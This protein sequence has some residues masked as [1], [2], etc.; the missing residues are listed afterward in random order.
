MRLFNVDDSAHRETVALLPWYVNGTLQHVERARVEQH[1]GECIACRGEL[2]AQRALR[3]L[4]RFESTPPALVSA[5]AGMHA[6]LDRRASR[7][8]P[9]GSALE[10]ARDWLR[11]RWL[12]WTALAQAICIAALVA[13]PTVPTG[14]RFHTLSSSRV[15][16]AHGDGVVVVFDDRVTQARMHALLHAFGARIVDGPNTRGAL[17]LAVPDGKQAAVIQAL[18]REPDVRFVQPAPGLVPRGG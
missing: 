9:L 7:T 8:A 2:E 16:P 13:V 5:L 3:E 18:E 14:E 15:P 12:A 4:V 11:P 6:R 10:R 1:V 17:T